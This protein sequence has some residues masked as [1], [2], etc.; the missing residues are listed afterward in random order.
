MYPCVVVIIVVV[1]KGNGDINFKHIKAGAL[2]KM[3]FCHILLFSISSVLCLEQIK[4]DKLYKCIKSYSCIV[5][6]TKCKR[7]LLFM[8]YFELNY[9]QDF[10][11]RIITKS[12]IRKVFK[13]LLLLYFHTIFSCSFPL[14]WINTRY[15]L[16]G[17][18]DTPISR[19][20]VKLVMDVYAFN[21]K[22][23]NFIH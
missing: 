22:R 10:M 13:R 16:R 9:H 8:L 23:K 12:K 5:N 6:Y 19:I 1:L 18:N 14:I 20:V 11:N 17:R 4:W 21:A 2:L 15:K 7:K 3:L